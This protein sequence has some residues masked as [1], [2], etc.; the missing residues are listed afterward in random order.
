MRP[1]GT[2]STPGRSTL[3]ALA[4]EKHRGPTTRTFQASRGLTLTLTLMMA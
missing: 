1:D 4:V 3:P 2:H